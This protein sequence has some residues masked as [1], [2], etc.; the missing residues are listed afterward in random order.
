MASNPDLTMLTERKRRNST[1]TIYVET[2]MSCQDNSVMIHVICVVIRAHLLKGEK[3]ASTL[4]SPRYD[5]FNDDYVPGGNSDSKNSRNS[6]T[7]IP[8]LNA[9]NANTTTSSNS[10]QDDSKAS[11]YAVTHQ[12][13]GTHPSD[14]TPPHPSPSVTE[15]KDFFNLIYNKSQLES[16]CII[17]TLIY[18]ERLIVKTKGDLVIRYNNWKAM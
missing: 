5:V 3:N 16:E 6:S 18:C 17:M 12:H 10:Y 4:C 9:N 15:I 2:T 1:G 14:L 13:E 11:Q 7:Y 8:Q